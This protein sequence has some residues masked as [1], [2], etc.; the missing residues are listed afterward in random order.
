MTENLLDWVTLA[1]NDNEMG[2]QLG[3]PIV[4]QGPLS[5]K[6]RERTTSPS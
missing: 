4:T 1:C 6:S 2:L 5:L 3:F